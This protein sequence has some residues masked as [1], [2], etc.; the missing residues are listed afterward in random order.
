MVFRNFLF[1]IFTLYS[2]E[3]KG[4]VLTKYPPSKVNVG[5]SQIISWTS[6]I[7]LD[8]V[9]I[10]LYQKGQ[11]KQNLGNT[12]QN[13]NNF[14]W[15]VGYNSD[16]GDSYL[17][18][19]TGKSNI[20]GTAWVNTPTFSIVLDDLSAG[21]IS[22]ITI[23][24]IIFI[25]LLCVCCNFSKRKRVKGQL[26]VPFNQQSIPVAQPTAATYPP[27]MIHQPTAA[28]YPPTI[29]V[30]PQRQG[31]SGS[32]VA[33]AAAGG[34]VTGMIVDE[35]VHSSGH[36]HH[37]NHNSD[38]GGGGFFGDNNSGGGGDSSYGFFSD[39]DNSGG[40]GDSSGGFF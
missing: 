38:F 1:F 17:I 29:V 24:G 4:I 33:G 10:D 13:L 19:V 23:V 26:N 21:N 16:L 35:I 3:A 12:N 31:Y 5:S 14:K 7:K 39:T 22:I 28:T 18:K 6:P 9:S 11:F 8:A 20:N 27:N 34:F 40:G 15:D 2:C 25:L 32:S 37:H 36:H 30:E